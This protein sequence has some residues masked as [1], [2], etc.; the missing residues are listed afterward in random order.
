MLRLRHLQA[1]HRL[2]RLGPLLTPLHPHLL[3]RQRVPLDTAVVVADEAVTVV[4]AVVVAVAVGAVGSLAGM[5]G[6]P[7]SPVQ[8]AARLP[9]MVT[10]PVPLSPRMGLR[11]RATA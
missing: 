11:A 3:L 10:Q 8:R 7:P 9:A 6:K 1:R 5:C 4:V 2:G